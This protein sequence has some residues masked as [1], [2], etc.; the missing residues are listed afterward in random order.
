MSKYNVT[1][2]GRS[3]DHY[4]LEDAQR[5]GSVYQVGDSAVEHARKKLRIA[6]LRGSKD[7]TTDIIEARD[8]LNRAIDQIES[9]REE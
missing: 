4:D 2:N 7:R 3:V 5:V 9:Q 1:I 8:S 6:G